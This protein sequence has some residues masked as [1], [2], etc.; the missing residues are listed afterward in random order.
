[1]FE[2]LQL[3]FCYETCT[4]DIRLVLKTEKVFCSNN[5]QEKSVQTVEK[6]FF[7]QHFKIVSHF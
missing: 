5:N 2:S 6:N 1:M 3:D 4:A 7:L